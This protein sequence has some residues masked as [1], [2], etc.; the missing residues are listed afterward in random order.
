MI[1]IVIAG[2]RT[3]NLLPKGAV[4]ATVGIF[5]PAYVFV[6]FSGPLVS[7]LRRS[8]VAGAFLDGVNVASLPLMAFVTYELG[9][10]AL[11]DPITMSAALLTALLL[12]RYQLN[13][14][15]LVLVLGGALLGLLLYR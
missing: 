8:P 7:R 10:S 6:A 2:L 5:L 13:S 14:A 12:I 1:L 11:I 15:W 3:A 4:L 9:K